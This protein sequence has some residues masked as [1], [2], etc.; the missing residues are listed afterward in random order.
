MS[1]E[2]KGV[3]LSPMISLGDHLGD[4]AQAINSISDAM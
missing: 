1:Q 2:A 4:F 3:A